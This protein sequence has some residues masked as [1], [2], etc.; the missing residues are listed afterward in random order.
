ML[1]RRAVAAGGDP[2]AVPAL[3]GLPVG[4]CLRRLREFPPVTG[5][6]FGSYGEASPGVHTLL[7]VLARAVAEREWREMGARTE[8]EARGIVMAQM[9]RQLSLAA[10][11]GHMRVLQARCAYVGLA[12]GAAVAE[13]ARQGAPADAHAAMWPGPEP[14]GIDGRGSGG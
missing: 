9:R 4:P 7:A 3:A 6:A 12:H 13:A 2:D 5:L 10:H 1:V 8:S 11:A 14:L